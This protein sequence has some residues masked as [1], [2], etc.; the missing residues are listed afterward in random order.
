MAS[1]GRNLSK[2][3]TAGTVGTLSVNGRTL[4]EENPELKR[5]GCDC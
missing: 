4:G 1:L 5:F 3:V 2:E